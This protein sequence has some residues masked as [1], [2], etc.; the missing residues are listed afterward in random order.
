[1]KEKNLKHK[2]ERSFSL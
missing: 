2:R 1:V